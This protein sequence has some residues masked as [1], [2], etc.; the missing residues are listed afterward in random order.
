MVETSIL[1]GSLEGAAGVSLRDFGWYF[2]SAGI[3]P[4]F[5]NFKFQYQWLAS[6]RGKERKMRRLT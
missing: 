2:E 5:L 4:P 3:M 6:E 1:S